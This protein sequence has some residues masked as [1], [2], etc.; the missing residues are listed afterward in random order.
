MLLLHPLLSLS[1]SRDRYAS[2]PFQRGMCGGMYRGMVPRHCSPKPTLTLTSPHTCTGGW[3]L[4]IA[5]L[6]PHS[7]SHLPTHTHTHT[8]AHTHADA[9][10]H[11]HTYADPHGHTH[12]HA[13]AHSESVARTRDMDHRDSSSDAAG[14]LRRSLRSRRDGRQLGQKGGREGTLSFGFWSAREVDFGVERN[15]RVDAASLRLETHSGGEGE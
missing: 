13:H 15:E 14:D 5:P 2:P 12:A 11:T 10:G 9:H 1:S 4:D 7:H 3:S 6:S 8:H